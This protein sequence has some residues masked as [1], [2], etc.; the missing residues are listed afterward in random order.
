MRKTVLQAG[1]RVGMTALLVLVSGCF[2]VTS[3]PEG[4]LRIATQP[5]YEQR[6][7]FFLWGLVGESHIDT[8]KVCKHG[9]SQ[10]QSQTTFVDGLLGVV[11][12]GIYA[13]TSAKIWCK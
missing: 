13:P 4:G 12:L 9:V 3:R 6:Q 10:L 2:S 5:T 8:N 1:K 7:D 11:T